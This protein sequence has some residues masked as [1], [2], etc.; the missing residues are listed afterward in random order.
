MHTR[1]LAALTVVL[2]TLALT[3][4]PAAVAQDRPD[5]AAAIAAQAEAMKALQAMN[6]VWRGSAWTLLPSGEKRTFT[7]TERIGP[8]L[9]GTLKVVEGRG[10]DDQGALAFNAFGIISF[11]PATRA[12]SLRSY[13]QG[14]TGDFALKLSDDG[15]AWEIAAGPATIRYTAVL[16]DGTLREIGERL[17]SGR[18]PLRIF[19]MS[20][21]RVADS[22]WPSAGA[23]GPK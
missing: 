20:L 16:K 9:Q 8:M 13:A 23:I 19:E 10:Y 11:D 15:Y 5:P 2:T 3:V 22:D 6:G 17:M 21:T 12:Y 7:Q 18:E 14:R 4:G 1:H